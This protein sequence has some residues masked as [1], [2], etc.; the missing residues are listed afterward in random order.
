MI[1]DLFL[2]SI[3]I[4]VY[5]SLKKSLILYIVISVATGPNVWTHQIFIGITSPPW[6]K[7]QNYYFKPELEHLGELWAFT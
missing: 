7:N 5:Y 6:M 4:K 2:D 1:Y 3:W